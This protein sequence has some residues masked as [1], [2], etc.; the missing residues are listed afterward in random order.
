MTNSEKIIRILK[1]DYPNNINIINF[2]ENYCPG[3]IKRIGN[4]IIVKGRSDRD[5]VYVSSKSEN[6][7]REIKSGLLPSDKNFAAIDEWM[8]PILTEGEKLKWMLKSVRL[9]HDGKIDYDSEKIDALKLEDADFVY[10]NSD[11]RDFISIEYVKDRINNGISSVIRID[12]KPAAWGMTQD[13]GAIGFLHVLAEYRRKG[14]GKKVTKDLIRK[15]VESGR[16]PFVHIQEENIFSMK[17]AK[18]LGFRRDKIVNWF[19][20]E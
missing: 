18:G 3:V 10:V 2:I 7:L 15:V 8:L 16:L 11:Y 13:D 12:G 5:W 9:I 14:F 19:E 6:E 20:L 1:E 4:S 17:L